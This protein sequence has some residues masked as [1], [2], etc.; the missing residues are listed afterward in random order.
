MIDALCDCIA[1]VFIRA[2]EAYQRALSLSSDDAFIH[3]ALANVFEMQ[4]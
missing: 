2:A 3:A 4:G 1:G